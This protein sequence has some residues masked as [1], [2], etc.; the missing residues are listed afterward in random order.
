MSENHDDT[1][2]FTN[3]NLDDVIFNQSNLMAGSDI[4]L[5]QALKIVDCGRISSY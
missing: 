5:R 2:M 3:Q 4:I 1:L